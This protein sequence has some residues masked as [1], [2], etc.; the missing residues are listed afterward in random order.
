[1]P[2][3]FVSEVRARGRRDFEKRG[4]AML[5]G[6]L[7]LHIA[8]R[9]SAGKSTKTFHG[10]ADL[11]IARNINC[12]DMNEVSGMHD[13]V[14]VR[15]PESFRWRLRW[16]KSAEYRL[17]APSSLSTTAHPPARRTVAFL[18]QLDSGPAAG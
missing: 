14:V 18:E 16:R 3:P 1:L 4:T 15:G 9:R 10:D 6:M 12:P 8:L 7:L 13:V 11:K 2:V 5:S 17:I